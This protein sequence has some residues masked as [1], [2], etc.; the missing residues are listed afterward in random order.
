MH[1]PLIK[2]RCEDGTLYEGG[3]PETVSDLVKIDKENSL[4]PEVL[5]EWL[6]DALMRLTLEEKELETLSENV[7]RYVSV[8]SVRN[9]VGNGGV[10]AP[11]YSCPLL[12]PYAREGY[13]AISQSEAAQSIERMLEAVNK[14]R[15]FSNSQS[16]KSDISGLLDSL[17]EK[18]MELIENIIEP[19][20]QETEY[21]IFDKPV[22][23][24]DYVRDNYLEFQSCQ[25]SVHH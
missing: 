5:H 12:L 21:A 20:N 16:K 24:A 25:V 2:L 22:Q 23:L 8:W 3:K 7:K 18:Q 17:S 11:L 1:F 6:W 15:S 4:E 19:G 14:A 13:L 10:Y 9:Y